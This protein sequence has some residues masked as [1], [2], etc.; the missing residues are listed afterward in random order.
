V[1]ELA[2]RLATL[3]REALVPIRHPERPSTIVW[4]E[5]FEIAG[6]YGPLACWRKGTGA[7]VL[8]VHGWEGRHGDLDA[9]VDP[10]VTSGRCVVALD[11]PAHGETP[12]SSAT[13]LDWGQ[14][15]VD[16]AATLGPLDGIVAHSAGCPATALALQ[17]GLATR[18]VVLISSPQR[19]EVFVRWFA[20]EAGVEGDDLIAAMLERGLDVHALDVRKIVPRTS[21]PALLLHSADDRVV[22]VR[23]AEEIAALWPGSRFERLDGLGH[24]RILRDPGVVERV[25]AFISTL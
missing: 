20:S 8:L 9:F 24:S 18:C 12:G 25:L 5:R 13:L 14:A 1:D 2:A 17:R 3:A 6:A 22:D 21:L 15:I 19:Y 10:L 7:P 4:D 11:M 23:G 16:V